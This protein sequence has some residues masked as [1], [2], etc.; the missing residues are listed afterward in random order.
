MHVNVIDLKE[1]HPAAGARIG[2]I[3]LLY[4]HLQRIPLCITRVTQVGRSS[5]R[6]NNTACLLLA[7]FRSFS[8][9]ILFNY[10]EG[11]LKEEE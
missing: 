1:K 4:Y 3:S 8:A 7:T 2:T 5:I 10:D 11:Q 9:L 6:F